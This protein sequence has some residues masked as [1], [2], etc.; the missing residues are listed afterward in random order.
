[1][2]QK[3]VAMFLI[4]SIPTKIL[5][6]YPSN[7]SGLDGKFMSRSIKLNLTFIKELVIS[8]KCIYYKLTEFFIGI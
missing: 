1:M 4:Q 6:I 5:S 7:S 8:V 2:C 3:V